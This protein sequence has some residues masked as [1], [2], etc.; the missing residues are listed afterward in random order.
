MATKTFTIEIN[1]VS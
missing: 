1:G